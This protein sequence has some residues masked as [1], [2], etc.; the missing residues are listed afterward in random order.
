MLKDFPIMDSKGNNSRF[1]E[2]NERRNI[3]NRYFDTNDW[4]PSI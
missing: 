3:N 1:I 2:G 4:G